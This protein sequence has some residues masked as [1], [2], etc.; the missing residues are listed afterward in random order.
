VQVLSTVDEDSF[1]SQTPERVRAAR[2]MRVLFWIFTCGLLISSHYPRLSVG[3]SGD[4]PDKLLHFF[5]FGGWALL[6]WSSRY[7]RSPL[8]VVFL[9]VAFGAFDE[10]TQAIPIF[11]RS[12]DIQ[13][14][15]ADGAGGLVAMAWIHALGPTG[16]DGPIVRRAEARLAQAGW[17][18]LASTMNLG[19]LAVAT[20]FGALVGGVVL[21][22]VLKANP[23]I[24]PSTSVVFG[25]CLG[26]VAGFV[27][28]FQIGRQRMLTRLMASEESA[29][30]VPEASMRRLLLVTLLWIGVVLVG[31]AVLYVLAIAFS[32]SIPVLGGLSR[33]HESLG[34]NLAL[35]IDTAV[36]S[37]A[38]AFAARRARVRLAKLMAAGGERCVACRQDLNGVPDE[39]GIGRC[40]E[41][42]H[43]FH[44][45]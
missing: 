34:M 7:I 30:S 37:L 33:W 19:H 24:G 10:L 5:A 32:Q 26:G 27:A 21:T 3:T 36:V 4:S 17:R 43:R 20:I 11:G 44:R 42:G 31:M 41:C 29:P 25:A 28:G 40:P 6:L 9:S 18:L 45:S 38:A 16:V 14:L 22:I 39:N 8:L 12:A 23:V 1:E 15:L 13:D 2:N 35:M